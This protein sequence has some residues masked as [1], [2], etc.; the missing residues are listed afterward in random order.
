MC[1]TC[2]PEKVRRRYHIPWQLESGNVGDCKP[3]CG[4]WEP[5][6]GPV[7][8]QQRLLISEPPLQPQLISLYSLEMSL[9]APRYGVSLI[10]LVYPLVETGEAQMENSA[11][12]KN[13]FGNED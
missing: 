11:S 10:I 1:I 5:N 6:S 9:R 12:K 8:E 4:S 3:P 2:L 7:E 13:L